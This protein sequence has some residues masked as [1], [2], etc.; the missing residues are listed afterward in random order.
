MA[1]PKI[2]PHNTDAEQSVLGAILIDKD[3]VSLVSQI[4]SPHDFYNPLNGLIYS[5]MLLLYEEGKPIDILT[6]TSQLKKN[7]AYN[8]KIHTL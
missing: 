4:I 6:L 5:A 8:I 1:N 7:K 3:A 2:P